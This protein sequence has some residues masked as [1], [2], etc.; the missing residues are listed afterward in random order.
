M[1]TPCVCGMNWNPSW[2]T[3]KSPQRICTA[4]LPSQMSWTSSTLASMPNSNRQSE[5]LAE[6][7]QTDTPHSLTVGAVRT[8]LRKTNPRKAAS[9]DNIPGS[10]LS[11]CLTELAELFKD[12]YNLSTT[13]VTS[14]NDYR[15]VAL[16]PIVMKCFERIV[17]THMKKSCHHPCHQIWNC[18]C[19]HPHSSFISGKQGHVWECCSLTIA[20][21]FLLW[22]DTQP[23]L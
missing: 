19:C 23:P 3:G 16:S 15:P 2:S 10:V 13:I 4:S 18:Q 12:I 1:Q 6:E 20:G 17:M 5:V 22:S 7:G 14:L 9:P 11:V 21:T 8:A